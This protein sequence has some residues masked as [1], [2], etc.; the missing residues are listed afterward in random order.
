MKHTIYLLAFTLVSVF[1]TNY[2]N[3][4]G[5]SFNTTGTAADASAMLDVASTTKGMLVPRMTAAQK[6]AIT[7]PATGLMIFQTDGTAGFYYYT[8]SAWSA[9]GGSSLPSG[10]TGDLLY[11]NGSNWVSLA[12]GAN[13]KVLVVQSGVPT[14]MP[15]T[16]LTVGA[17]YGGGVIAY[18]L[19]SGDI[20]YDPSVQHGLIAATSDQSTGVQWHNGSYTNTYATGTAIGTGL[21]NTMAIIANQ[22][23]GSYAATVARSYTGG[24]NTDWYLPSKDELN[25]LYINRVSIGG[26]ASAAYWSS[27]ESVTLSAWLQVFGSGGQNFLFKN[28]AFYVRAVR[29]F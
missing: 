1:I 5:F 18:L 8:G 22:G 4:Q 10:T 23:A 11:Y 7:S 17:S 25:K 6:T 19:Q 15:T 3:A 20:G 13:G 26:F 29:A 28:Y 2:A 24:G 21:S 9:V 12:A 16:T 14:W 27:S